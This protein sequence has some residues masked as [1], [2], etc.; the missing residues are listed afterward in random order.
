M[1]YARNGILCSF[2]K[3]RHSDILQYDPNLRTLSEEVICEKTS[4]YS[5]EDLACSNSEGKLGNRVRLPEAGGQ[6]DAAAG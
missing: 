4:A 6:W 2:Q 3:Q 5:L 1:E